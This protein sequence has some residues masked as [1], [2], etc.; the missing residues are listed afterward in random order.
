MI[1]FLLFLSE[2]LRLCTL[3]SGHLM[4][5][6]LQRLER[7]TIDANMFEIFVMACL[8]IFAP[9]VG[10]NIVLTFVHAG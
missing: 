1:L 4:A 6:T 3:P 10:S 7:Y 2:L 8:V 5:S 9:K